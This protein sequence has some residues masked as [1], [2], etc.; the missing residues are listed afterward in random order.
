MESECN[1]K[2]KAQPP[3]PLVNANEAEVTELYEEN[4]EHVN[5]STNTTA[6]YELSEDI[7]QAEEIS[8]PIPPGVT[9]PV[10]TRYDSAPIPDAPVLHTIIDQ[11]QVK[12]AVSSME[13]DPNN[14]TQFE[15]INDLEATENKK[16]KLE[17]PGAGEDKDRATAL[18]D[19]DTDTT[20]KITTRNRGRGRG[21]GRGKSKAK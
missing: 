14:T 11:D 16:S 13:S 19:K 6:Y 15:A 1:N 10:S 18:D 7:A 21:P 4:A 3:V 20:P 12:E 17:E 8:Q 5:Q 9:T 2:I